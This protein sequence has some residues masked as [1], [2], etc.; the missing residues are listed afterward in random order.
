[1]AQPLFY[2]LLSVVIP[3]YNNAQ[4]LQRCL[5]SIAD[6]RLGEAVQVVV[7]DDGSDDA[8]Q[9][10]LSAV[11]DQ[12]PLPLQMVRQ[13]HKGAAAARNAG[14]DVAEGRFVCFVD[15]DDRVAPQSLRL[16][17]SLLEQMPHEVPL[18]HTG[19]MLDAECSAEVAPAS[20]DINLVTP[21]QVLRPRSACLDHTTYFID[22]HLLVA[23]PELRYPEEHHLLED[24]AFVL[25]L[26]ATVKQLYEAPN[27]RPYIRCHDA[28]SATSGAWDSRRCERF[29]PDI[30]WFLSLLHDYCVSHS[31][32]PSAEALYRRYAYLYLRVLAVKGC[33]WALLKPLR[34]QLLRDD[35]RP[36][37]LKERLVC[38]AAALR[39]VS[40]LSRLLR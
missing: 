4:L 2:M 40:S 27:C 26:L 21:G 10:L 9:P 28:P 11:A 33:P 18:L 34:S 17:V 35:F 8:E 36:H 19:P 6:A 13:A 37:S 16:V 38:N 20:G 31:A 23:H 5:R 39:V 1:M 15:A 32:W 12:P 30:H 25:S 3:T 29:L 7:V 24:S 22:R 14:I